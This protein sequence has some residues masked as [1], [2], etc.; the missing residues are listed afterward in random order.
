MKFSRST[1]LILSVVSSSRVCN[2]V[3]IHTRFECSLHLNFINL[4][5]RHNR[6]AGSTQPPLRGVYGLKCG[7]SAAAKNQ[8]PI[9]PQLSQSL[10]EIDLNADYK[11]LKVQIV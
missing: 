9:L 8:S 6:Q 4:G 1:S 3:L 7:R 5:R 10:R 11:L 2:V